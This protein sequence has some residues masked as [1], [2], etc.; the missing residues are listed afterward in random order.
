MLADLCHGLGAAESTVRTSLGYAREF[1]YLVKRDGRW[2]LSEQ[3]QS[4]LAD[5]G[6]LEGADGFRFAAFLS[7]QPK[8]AFN[9]W[10]DTE[11]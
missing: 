6:R 8:R 1:G 11:R 9:R 3:C 4:L 2:Q 10:S 7:G 5:Y